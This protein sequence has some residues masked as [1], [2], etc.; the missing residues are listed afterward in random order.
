MS[1]SFF[2]FGF[3]TGI[4]MIFHDD[5]VCVLER[6]LNSLGLV[7]NINAISTVFYHIDHSLQLPMGNLQTVNDGMID[8]CIPRYSFWHNS[9][10]L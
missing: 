8:G 6:R 3:H 4:Q 5:I 1:I 7:D 2:H 9:I 10:P